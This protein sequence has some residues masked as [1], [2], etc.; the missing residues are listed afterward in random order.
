MPNHSIFPKARKRI[1][2]KILGQIFEKILKTTIDYGIVS[3]EGILVDSSIVRA[4]ASADS[5][6][7]INLSP[8]EYWRKLDESEKIKSPTGRKP[9]SGTPVNTGSHF[10]G[11]FDKDKIGKRRRTNSSFLKK[12]STIDP[13]ATLFYRLGAGSFL[14]YKAHM[15]TDTNGIITAVAASLSS[16]HDT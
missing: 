11:T 10:K 13:D 15:A 7:E 2:E 5:I 8:E 9:K 12:R 3:K 4:D 1:G 6:L 14:S 16:L